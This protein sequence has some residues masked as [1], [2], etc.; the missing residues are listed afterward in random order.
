MDMKQVQFEDVST[1]KFALVFMG[2]CIDTEE[3][4]QGFIKGLTD[5]LVRESVLPEGTTPEAAWE[6]VSYL[7]TTGG[8]RD[9]LYVVN[10]G[11]PFRMG[12][13]AGVRH[14]VRDLKWVSDWKDFAGKQYLSPVQRFAKDEDCDTVY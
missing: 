8:R 14:N 3:Q 1:D 12:R 2:C 13:L 9:I 11:A 7:I 4:R 6:S 10:P 5:L